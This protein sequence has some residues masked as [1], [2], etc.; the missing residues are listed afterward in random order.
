MD[1]FYQVYLTICKESKLASPFRQARQALPEN[2][3]NLD[4]LTNNDY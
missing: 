4:A 3:W 1:V 2:P